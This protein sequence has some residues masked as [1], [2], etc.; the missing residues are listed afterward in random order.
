MTATRL[1]HESGPVLG[2]L[3]TGYGGL[4]LGTAAALGG[5]RLVWTADNDPDIARLLAARFP[6]VPNLGDLRDVDWARVAKV[7]VLTAG[8]P[9]QDISA[10]G[11]GAGIEKGTR[12]N[13]WT[14]VMDA[15]RHLGPRLA[16]IENVA[17]LRWKGRGMDTVLADLA[18]A[19]YDAN[20]VSVRASDVGA[21][22][23]R[24]R[25]FIAAHPHGLRRLAG[26]SGPGAAPSQRPP[27]GAARRHPPPAHHFSGAEDRA[28]HRWTISDTTCQRRHQGQSQPTG[29]QGR[30]HPV[31]RGRAAAHPA[32]LGHRNP[33]SA[34]RGGVAS[35]PVPDRARTVDWGR[36]RAAIDRW[37][38]VLGRP[39]PHPTEPGTRGQ[40]R[41][42]PAF[43]EWLMGLEPGWTTD[44]ALGLSR[45]AQLRALGNGVV[46]QQAEVAL[47]RL[48]ADIATARPE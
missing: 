24:E 42:S 3:C 44:P 18:E 1:H 19:G 30:S 38:H 37:E 2:S 11:R 16:V 48:L 21:P 26:T 20:W 7:D 25:V 14:F 13:V 29:I 22:H 23:Q 15:I 10:A 40:P 31:L 34:C 47:T 41:L 35:A 28:P 32:R 4:D 6:D 27:G 45:P 8:F 5:A 17:A 46:P 43:V 39:A 36:Y 33:R 12:S 9:C